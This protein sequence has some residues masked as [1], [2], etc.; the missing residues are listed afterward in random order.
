MPLV[1]DVGDGG[2]GDKPHHGV[3]R[4]SEARY[5]M[6]DPTPSFEDRIFA[7]FEEIVYSIDIGEAVVQR[8]Q[9]TQ[10]FILGVDSKV[11]K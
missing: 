1:G 5:R 9:R 3:L 6:T 11:Q 2:Y 8:A 4:R 10:E 7:V